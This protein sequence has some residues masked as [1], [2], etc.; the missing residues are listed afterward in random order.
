MWVKMFYSNPI[1]EI[2]ITGAGYSDDSIYGFRN[3]IFRKAKT[4]YMV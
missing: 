3:F 2:L 1:N 4:E